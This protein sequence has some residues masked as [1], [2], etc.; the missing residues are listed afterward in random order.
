MLPEREVVV[1][2]GMQFVV[3]W[4]AGY[5][6]EHE[7]RQL[8]ALSIPFGIQRDGALT[9]RY[10]RL[11]RVQLICCVMPG[12][13]SMM[14]LP[15]KTRTTWINHAPV[16]RRLSAEKIEPFICTHTLCV[17]P[18]RVDVDVRASVEQFFHPS[19]DFLD[20]DDAATS[21]TA[22]ECGGLVR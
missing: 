13:V 14:I 4:D 10:N 6:V 2:T 18:I 22:L 20:L 8:T 7:I 19:P 15:V 16:T 5:P 21:F 1:S 9:A 17:D 12:M 11:V 3:E